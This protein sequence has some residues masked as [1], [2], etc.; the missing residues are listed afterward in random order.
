[1]K[2]GLLEMRELVS[3]AIIALISLTGA[4]GGVLFKYG[5]MKFGGGEIQP[6]NF[7]DIGWSIR[8][9]FTPAIFFGLFCLFIGRFLMGIPLS[10]GGLG[11]VT[12]TVTIMTILF[13]I[14]ASRI[15]FNESYSLKVY[16][17]LLLAVI[18]IVL[19]GEG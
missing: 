11:K 5:T 8:Y 17:G 14:I 9:F 2:R 6:Q 7:F 12:T 1:M 18:S 16:V 3:W 19:I 4:V 10:T 13:T 15:V